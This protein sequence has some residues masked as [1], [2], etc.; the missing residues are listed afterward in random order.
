MILDPSDFDDRPYRIPNQQES[1]DFP[2]FIEDAEEQILVQLLGY[3][4]FK[5]LEDALNTSNP[6]Q[7]YVDLRDGAEYTSSGKTYKYNGLV[8]LL[9]PAVF[10]L[11]IDQNAYKF[12]N[13]GHVNNSPPQQSTVIDSEPFVVQA[14]NAF[15]VRAGGSCNYS[16][17]TWNRMDNLYGFYQANKANYPT[18]V[19]KSPELKN[20]LGF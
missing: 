13:I 20:R 11:W 16:R 9:R 14:W 2:E 15:V 5:E 19:W 4:F 1:K 10:S 17:S 8:D 18:L 6:D 7:I 3:E 12:T